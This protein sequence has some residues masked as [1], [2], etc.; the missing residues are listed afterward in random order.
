[1]TEEK[2][3]SPLERAIQANIDVSGAQFIDGEYW[4]GASVAESIIKLAD[5]RISYPYATQAVRREILRCKKISKKSNVYALTDLWN[6]RLHEGKRTG[7]YSA[8]Q[9]KR[10]AAARLAVADKFPES[11]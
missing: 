3:L 11:W 4:V 7:N 10:R 8:G 1:M 5:P 9:K 2:E 6:V